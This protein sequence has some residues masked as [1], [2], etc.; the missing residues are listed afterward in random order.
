MKI[1]R[2]ICSVF[3]AGPVLAA[4]NVPLTIQ[5]AL[6]SGGTSGVVRT[7]EP[8]CMGVPL[9]D[10]AGITSTSAL[11]LSGA[12]AGQ[13]RVLGSWPDGKYKW[14]KVCGIV[15]NVAA[16]G[17]ATV[18]LTD[19]GS[20]NF[21]GS[22]LATDNGSTITVSTGSSQ[23]TIKKAKFNV[24]DA[25]T[26]GTATILSTS[27]AATRGLVIMGPDP[28]L[29][30]PGNVT[31]GTCT[32]LYSSANDP[33]STA[34]IEENGPVMTVIKAT[35]NHMDASGHPYMQYTA[36]LY[37]YK[38]KNTVKVV[39]SLRNANYD[40]S[41]VPSPDNAGNTFNTAYKGFQSYE[42][43]I[44]PGITGTLTYNI[45]ANGVQSVPAV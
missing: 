35:G 22:N 34:V 40:T 13:F 26:I 25:A 16:G 6:Y 10:A 43:R 36:R 11:T 37:F 3:F 31:C 33:N 12:S 38:G 20:G 41:T 4:I 24:I 42:L 29:P 39:S 30:F 23:F 28:S 32:T 45:E 2:L 5:E 27:S 21:G 14:V 19:G 17:S 9:A 8:F 18:T 44:N 15:P 7:N 1:S